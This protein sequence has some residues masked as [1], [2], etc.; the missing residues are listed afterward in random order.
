MS[1][2]R[3][4]GEKRWYAPARDITALTPNI[5]SLAF[6]RVLEPGNAFERVFTLDEAELAPVAEALAKFCGEDVILNTRAY[7]EAVLA[8]GLNQ[9]PLKAKAAL[10]AAAFEVLMQ[11]F[12]RAI[13]EATVIPQGEEPHITQYEPKDLA[14]SAEMAVKMMAMPRWKRKLHMHFHS[15]RRWISRKID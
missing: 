9:V 2:M 6:D 10:Y 8:S 4:P 12:Y 5:I 14:K 7:N 3:V 13:Q 11:C 1:Q 15:I